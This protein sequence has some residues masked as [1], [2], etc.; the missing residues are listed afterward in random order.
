MSQKGVGSYVHEHGFGH[1]DWNFN[2]DF[3]ID[4]QVVG[5]T[6]ALPAKKYE[7]QRFGLVLATFDAGGWRAAGYYDGAILLDK[8][9][10]PSA[11]AVEQMAIDVFEL[12]KINQVAHRYMNQTLTQIEN[13]IRSDFVYFR[14]GGPKRS[15]CRI[16][17]VATNTAKHFRARPAKD[18]NFVQLVRRAVQGD[19][20]ARSRC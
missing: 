10:A 7:G 18:G 4:G 17:G 13:S 2:I 11:S 15:D 9:A 19:H 16:P 1:E 8:P 5:Y 6:V 20:E 14:L 3:A 12:A